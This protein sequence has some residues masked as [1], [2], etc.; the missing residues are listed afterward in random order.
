MSDE[1]TPF[2]LMRQYEDGLSG[3]VPDERE[4]QDFLATQKYGVFNEPN[5]YGSGRGKRALLWQYTLKL[6]PL[7]FT[8]RQTTGDCFVAGTLVRMGDGTEKPIEQVVAGDVVASP[9][10]GV[11]R[12]LSTFSKPYDGTVNTIRAEGCVDSVTATADHKFVSFDSKEEWNWMPVGV[13]GKGDR[14]FTPSTDIEDPMPHVY[15]LA[16]EYGCGTDPNTLPDAPSS[17]PRRKVADDGWVRSTNGKH[18]CRRNIELTPDVGWLIGLWLAEGSTD[19]NPG[20]K[21]HGLTWNLCKDELSIAQRVRKVVRDTFGV[22]STIHSMPSKPNCL[23]V[24]V[25]CAPLARWM[26]RICGSGNTY[27]KRVPKE[28]FASSAMT[29]MACLRGWL[30]GDGCVMTA[31]RS[32]RPQYMRCKLSG[33]SVCRGLVRDMRYIA[34]SCG[35]RC[36]DT[37]R[38][39]RGRSKQASEL[40]FYGESAVAVAPARVSLPSR[41]GGRQSTVWKV[42]GGFAPRIQSTQASQFTGT[43]YCIEVEHDHA[44]V[45]NGYAVHNCVSHGSRNARDTTRAVE[46]LVKREPE[47]WFKRGATEPTYGAR[48]HG[49]Q[50][51]SPARASKFERDVGFLARHDYDVVDLS[52][53]NADI[54]IRWGRTG[55]PKEVQEL[56]S[57]NKVGVIT[58]V[59]SQEEL[60]DALFNGYAAHSGQSA[61]WA[62]SP[63]SKNIHPR[64][65]PWN[66][67]LACLGYDS[68]LEYWPFTV[69]FLINSWG[70][71]N[72]P[73][74]D[75]PK[76]YPPQVPGMIVTSAEDF[77]VC[78]SSGDCWVYGSIDGYP[79]QRLPDFGAIGM[80]HYGE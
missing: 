45:A 26:Y 47:A 53:Y 7:S 49:G 11:Q 12:V 63:N 73:I 21:P 78:V 36:S 46:I 31:R 77:D 32:E 19:R 4:K 16:E 8:E 37:L 44:F 39:A 2:Q 13:L 27:A 38:K 15:D 20:G 18:P 1:L 67:D 3:Y 30:E 54:G 25:G 40:H 79:A 14:V 35:V 66:H 48:G 68:T 17:R 28:V 75:W 74:K 23:F 52:K 41:A 42:A 61:G 33:V 34:M 59:R 72:Q 6:D 51:M 71:W 5:I 9:F 69:W 80:L 70:P 62:A 22:E 65:K 10:G 56:C 55:V 24:S 60:M 50:G 43:V 57:R 29:R 76:D 58:Q 64:G